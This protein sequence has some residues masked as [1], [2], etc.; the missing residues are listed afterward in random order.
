MWAG[1]LGGCFLL[2]WFSCLV[3]CNSLMNAFSFA[4]HVARSEDCCLGLYT[5]ARCLDFRLIAFTTMSRYNE[6]NS[7][8]ASLLLLVCP[9]QM[10]IVSCFFRLNILG[11]IGG[12]RRLSNGH[13]M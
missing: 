3:S 7:L 1:S 10:Y 2:L 12:Y 4:Q 9:I 8:V 13:K 6:K 5:R 11:S